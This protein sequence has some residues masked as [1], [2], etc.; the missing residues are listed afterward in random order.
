M[1]PSISEIILNEDDDKFKTDLQIIDSEESSSKIHEEVK[2][3]IRNAAQLSA[4]R[5][6]VLQHG[7]CPKCSAALEQRMFVSVCDSCGWSSYSTPRTK[8]GVKVHISNSDKPIIGDRVFVVKNDDVLIL[9]GEVIVARVS[10]NAISWIEYCW[11]KDELDN[12]RK[13][14]NEK[15]TISCGWCGKETSPDR[16][17]F[18]MVQIAFGSTQER[19]CFC[20]DECFEAFRQMYPS[21]VHRDC[22]ERSCENCNLCIKRYS[23]ES[24]GLRT[25][26]KDLISINKNK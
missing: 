4:K 14:I 2:K 26:A 5:L 1:A 10:S 16:D 18:H 23:D 13:M 24:E 22:Y 3:E 8:D 19:F 21:R 20:C 9:S 6:H 11:E 7:R 15:L 17:G 25:V 12:R